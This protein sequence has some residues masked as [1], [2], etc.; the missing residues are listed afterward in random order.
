ML[1][2]AILAVLVL[3][4]GGC[5]PSCKATCRKVLRCEQGASAESLEACEASCVFQERRYEE[6]EDDLRRDAFADHKRC[7]TRS[8]CSEIDAGRC[9]DPDVFIF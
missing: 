9:Y 3:V 7:L 4:G 8:R 1:R 2:S 6:R 5:E